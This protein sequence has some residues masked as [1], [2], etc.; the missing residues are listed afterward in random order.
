MDGRPLLRAFVLAAWAGVVALLAIGCAPATPSPVLPSPKVAAPAEKEAA[1]PAVPAVKEAP[2]PAASPVAKAPAKP[3]EDW[4]RVLGD[5]KREGQVVVYGLSG[6]DRQEAL[7][8]G[9][10]EKY[11]EIRMDYTGGPGSQIAAKAMAERA[12]GLYLADVYIGGTTDAIAN[13]I[14]AGAL[15]PI[16]PFLLGPEV[17]D[18]S[19]WAGG[20]FYFADEAEVHNLIFTTQ[21]SVP[22]AYNGD[23]VAAG[24]VKSWKDL[25]APKWRG[26][27]VM[28][29]PRMAG[30]GLAVAT[31]WYITDN[32]GKP[33][34]QQLFSQQE[35][36]VSADE[37]LIVDWVARGQYPIGI[38][39]SDS[40]ATELKNKGVPIE[41]AGSLQE[42]VAINAGSGSLGVF[43]RAPHP[44][45]AKVYLNW[46]LSKETQTTFSK[47]SSQASRRVDVPKDH[48]PDYVLPKPGVQYIDNSL[49]RA[50][51][52]R[53]ETVEFL[54]SVIPS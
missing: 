28:R 8:R 3:T 51:K 53:D 2:K 15:Q 45:A 44:N 48:L 5:A 7:T 49:E 33:F 1:K 37:R 50:V 38:G 29:D 46:L 42:G 12:G 39:A 19:S 23:L 47:A 11:P 32:L 36:V 52:L 35:V 6:A 10:S 4:D 43:D 54:K 41:F 26:K 16:R 24:E 25:L 20:K 22:F 14:P 13:F 18:T 30:S 9:F 21:V 17:R 27:I 34:M 40:L 31:F